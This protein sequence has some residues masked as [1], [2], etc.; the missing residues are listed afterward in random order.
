[1]PVEIQYSIILMSLKV[2]L[3][4]AASGLIYAMKLKIGL[5][6]GLTVKKVLELCL[7][8]ILVLVLIDGSIYIRTSRSFFAGY[9]AFIHLSLPAMSVLVLVNIVKSIKLEIKNCEIRNHQLHICTLNSSLDGLRS[10]KHDYNNTVQLIG[11][12]LALNNVDG[13]RKYF[14][15]IE[16]DA[17]SINNIYP[18][19]SYIRQIPAIYS[20]LLTKK[21]F[22][23]SRDINFTIDIQNEI[24]IND[25]RV[26]D[27]CRIMG[28]LLDN[29]FE[30]AA[31][32]SK[33]LVALHIAKDHK[34]NK[35]IVEI[36]NTYACEIILDRLFENGYTTKSNHS[37]FGLWEIKKLLK[38]YKCCSIHTAISNN[39]FTQRLEILL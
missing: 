38:R 31:E 20:M 14:S 9:G 3:S 8:Y 34:D 19:N 30:A 23:E 16:Q 28:I 32:S 18:L 6:E 33:R 7:N 39:I 29:A 17:R 27:F 11:G 5:P 15:Q 22:S 25:I 1:M 21:A 13:L 36:S 4:A 35:L 12:Y 10:F 24:A 37:G 26:L 2:L